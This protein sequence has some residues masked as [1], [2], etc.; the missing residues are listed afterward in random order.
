MTR[1]TDT[2]STATQYKSL[3][4]MPV[5]NRRYRLP[6]PPPSV[7]EALRQS[8]ALP[9]QL[10]GVA[11][12]LALCASEA[13]FYPTAWG[14]VALFVL[15][16][17]ALTMTIVGRPA[18]P[19]GV[20]LA[21][22]VLFA[23]YSAWSLLS[24]TWADQQADAWAGGH[25]A[26]AYWLVLALF[27]LWPTRASSVRLLI[28]SFSLGVAV[29]GLIE[30]LRADSAAAGGAFFID[31]RFAEPAGYIN[32]NVAL[33]TLGMLGCLSIGATRRSH[34]AV[35]GVMLG[36]AGLLAG[37]ALL[38]QSRGWVLALPLALI[39]LVAFSPDRLRIALGA[40]LIGI[41]VL[42]VRGPIL[43][44]HDDYSPARFD[45]L[46]SDATAALVLMAVVVCGVG[47][48]WAALERR[49]KATER[50]ARRLAVATGA[51]LAAL[52]L[53]AGAA[54][55]VEA[56]DPMNR[57][58]EAWSDFK[59]GG[60]PKT[61]GSRFASGGSNRYDFW[62]VALNAFRQHPLRGIGAENF[63]ELYLRVGNST[64][65]ARYPHSLEVGVLSQLGIVGALLLA[66]AFGALLVGVTSLRRAPR[67]SRAAAV[68]ALGLF[69]YWLAHASVDW[70]W[71]FPGLTAPPLA[72]LASAAALAPRPA[73][74]RR[75]WPRPLLAASALAALV[76]ALS[77]AALWLSAL[78][79]DRGA[80]IWRDDS[81]AAFEALD[82]AAVLNPLS[83]VPDATA[84][85]I[86]LRLDR[87][88]DA[89][90]LFLD[91]LE[92][93]PNNA[94]AALELGLI[95]SEQNRRPEALRFLRRSLAENPNDSL[96]AS[97]LNDVR[98][99]KR[100]SLSAVNAKIGR[101]ARSTAERADGRE[102]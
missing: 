69:A 32:A 12:F 18:R 50:T 71:E 82:R 27:S 58:T 33:W 4:S 3:R 28:G 97:V 81:Q 70:F 98:E 23:A 7:S 40:L 42:A 63:Q 9:A 89:R 16:L 66:G 68:A 29:I 5:D 39:V 94:Y 65:K 48:A 74:A 85:T 19:P 67:E 84:A 34:P 83:D 91:V 96:I 53:A 55:L 88:D 51:L 11:A 38:G 92:R 54:A 90:R 44:V 76:L 93:E 17:L 73:A 61:G 14:P 43:A 2:A 37:L 31:L 26:F 45:A 95:A 8:P 78:Y 20:V 72:L 36:G 47:A 62:T 86:A 99:G 75:R 41:G 15:A 77:I 21:A 57:V 46:L 49:T 59:E 80:E 24:T 10:L 56:G 35:R 52:A 60:G 13:G 101:D 25:R 1:A 22:L 79:L 6:R 102:K 64:E 30:I 87:T 100:T